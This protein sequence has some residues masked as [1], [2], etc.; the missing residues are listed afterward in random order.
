MV[1]LKLIIDALQSIDSLSDVSDVSDQSL[2]VVSRQSTYICILASTAIPGDLL[3]MVWGSVSYGKKY[4]EGYPKIFVTV[5]HLYQYCSTAVRYSCT[6]AVAST[7]LVRYPSTVV[8]SAA[9]APY[10]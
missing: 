8:H 7:M 4:S 1:E 2:S 5:V 6:T 3:A 9:R 10:I